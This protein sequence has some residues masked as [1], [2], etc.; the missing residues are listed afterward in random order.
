MPNHKIIF[1]DLQEGI[2]FKDLHPDFED[3]ELMSITEGRKI[4]PEIEKTLKYDR[5]DII[6]VD[7]ETP[8]LVIE[9]TVEVP[10]GHNVGQRFGRL[11]GAAEEGIPC[12]YFFPYVA[13][14][15][16]GE[17]SGPRF[18]NLRL[19]R[20]IEIIENQLDGSITTI[21]WPVDKDWEVIRQDPIK[22]KRVKEYITLFLEYYNQQT[23]N[24]CQAIKD[25]YFHENE[26]RERDKFAEREIKRGAVYD[27][28]P[29]S[30][31]IL[32]TKNIQLP[33]PTNELSEFDEIVVYKA[34]IENLRSDPYTGSAILYRYLYINGEPKKSRG[35]ILHFPLI[36]VSDWNSLADTR[37]DVRN[38]KAVADGILFA[39]GYLSFK[40]VKI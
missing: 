11:A 30:V 14:K 23:P 3:A 27:A 9:R 20:T 40:G 15:H 29:K 12:V 5:P 16:G 6:L 8:I 22:D 38:F 1:D 24:I 37:K 2:W 34:G 36:K 26:I 21:N 10:S 7:D 4:Y 35:L 31:E 39:D 17:T 32:P 13:M 18:V 28:P 25:S 19:F 33:I